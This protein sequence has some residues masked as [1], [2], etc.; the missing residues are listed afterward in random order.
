M[1]SWPDLSASTAKPAMLLLLL[2]LVYYLSYEQIDFGFL[3]RW[4]ELSLIVIIMIMCHYTADED[5]FTH[6]FRM[7]KFLCAGIH[8][9]RKMSGCTVTVS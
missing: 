7:F 1:F 3:I 4:C 6:V 8:V 5:G 2:A 9:F